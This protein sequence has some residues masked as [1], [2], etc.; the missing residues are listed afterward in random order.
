MSSK[1]WIDPKSHYQA[2][3]SV[4]FS[5]RMTNAE[6]TDNNGITRDRNRTFESEQEFCAWARRDAGISW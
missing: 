5:G 2:T 1:T 3:G 6:V 4:D